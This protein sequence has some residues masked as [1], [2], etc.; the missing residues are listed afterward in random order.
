MNT[1]QVTAKGRYEIVQLDHGKANTINQE[2][3][4]ELLAYFRAAHT[5][6]KIEGVILTGK[7]K[8]FSAG[9][10]VIE[11]YNYDETQVKDFWVSFLDLVIEMTR[12]PKPLISAITGHSPAGGCVFACCC[13]YRVMADD[14]RFAIGLN[15][16]PVGIVLPDM[17][18]HLFSF[19]VG[20]GTA[21]RCLMEGKLMPPSIAHKIGL[22]DELVALENVLEAAEEQ[23]ETYLSFGQKTWQMSKINLRAELLGKIKQLPEEALGATMEQWWAQETRQIMGAVVAS[24]TKK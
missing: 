3:V 19:W 7:P 21:Y 8:F 6:D 15:E 5:N 14:A 11:L 4:H 23:M 2:M 17:I 9:L 1:L 10:D 13:D 12:F 20:Q 22:I 24:L 18:F 16:I